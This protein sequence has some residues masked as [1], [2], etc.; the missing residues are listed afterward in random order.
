VRVTVRRLRLACNVAMH[1]SSTIIKKLKHCQ[2]TDW[3]DM[4]RI[5]SF[6]L[7]LTFRHAIVG[8]MKIINTCSRVFFPSNISH[9]FTVCTFIDAWKTTHPALFCFST[10]TSLLLTLSHSSGL[11]TVLL[12]W[13]HKESK[14]S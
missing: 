1:Q 2:M 14:I 12:Q 5:L 13:T 9:S 6:I 8:T 11:S 3:K 10:I 7:L 4:K